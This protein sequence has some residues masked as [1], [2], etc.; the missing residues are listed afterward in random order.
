MYEVPSA[1]TPPRKLQCEPRRENMIIRTIVSGAIKGVKINSIRLNMW[2]IS[3][4]RG[5]TTHVRT[6]LTASWAETARRLCLLIARVSFGGGG[7]SV[8]L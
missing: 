2:D 6:T 1:A 5:Q 4:P 3:H 8:T 7:F